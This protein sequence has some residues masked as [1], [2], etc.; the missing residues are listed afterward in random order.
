MKK[1]FTIVELLVVIGIIAL[2]VSLIV[3]AIAN[4]RGINTGNSYVPIQVGTNRYEFPVDV[5]E[6]D[7]FSAHLTAF[8]KS[9]PELIVT[10]SNPSDFYD[11]RHASTLLL[12]R[13]SR[14]TVVKPLRHDNFHCQHTAW[15]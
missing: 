5:W 8:E 12:L 13:Q 9:H 3:P 1:A 2:L 14:P 10:Q 11:G 4:R 7:D 6:P 15:E